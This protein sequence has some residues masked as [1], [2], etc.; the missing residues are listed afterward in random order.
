MRA[1]EFITE[2]WSQKY[3]RSINC[4]RPRGF[5][6]RAHCAGRKKNES[7]NEDSG[8]TVSGNIATIAQP[9]GAVITR[10]G[11]GNTAKYA[12]SAHKAKRKKHDAGR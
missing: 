8:A 5:S 10:Q 4:N 7:V 2:K 9:M 11:F 1:L 6:Q 12:N 3:K